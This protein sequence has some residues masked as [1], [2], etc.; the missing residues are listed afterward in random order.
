MAR[1]RNNIMRLP[2]DIRLII[3]ALLHDGA[4]YDEVRE[5]EVVAEALAEKK[6]ALHNN[7][8]LAYREG[9]EFGEYRK[10]KMQWGHELERNHIAASF[11]GDAEGAEQIARIADYELMKICIEKLQDGSELESKELS[12]ISRAVASYNRTRIAEDK[13]DTKREHAEK[14]AQYQATIAD[15]SEKV[16]KMS[17]KLASMPQDNKNVIDEMN[18]FVKGE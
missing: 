12:S 11:L 1:P 5:D 4:T 9:V 14:E 6:L 15:L 13:E 10:R 17:E 7:S 3:C 2:V 18:N 8:F 16:I